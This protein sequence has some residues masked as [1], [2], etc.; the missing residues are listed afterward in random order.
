MKLLLASFILLAAIIFSCKNGTSTTKVSHSV[1]DTSTSKAVLFMSITPDLKQVWAGL[2]RR[3]VIPD[4]ATW[5]QKDS[6]TIKKE[7]IADSIYYIPY[8]S[9]QDTATKTVY[10]DS[11]SGRIKTNAWWNIPKEYVRSGWDDAD[12]AT[13][14]LDSVL[15][16]LKPKK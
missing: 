13:R 8:Q 7:R 15:R 9:W 16:K 2:G 3:V 4:T 14:E 11:A 5:K 1:S 10:I 12:L 6:V